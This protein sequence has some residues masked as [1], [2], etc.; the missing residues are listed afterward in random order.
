M[1]EKGLLEIFQDE[2]DKRYNN[3]LITNKTFLLKHEISQK[4]DTLADNIFNDFTE[5]ELLILDDFL[6]RLLKNADKFKKE[7]GDDKAW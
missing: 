6:N 2:E 1:K 7:I 3:I 4:R 5:N